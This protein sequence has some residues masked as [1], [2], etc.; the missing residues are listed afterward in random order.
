MVVN[1]QFKNERTWHKF[2]QD[3]PLQVS[4]I[5][6]F[7]L[8][9]HKIINGN[10]ILLQNTMTGEEYSQDKTYIPQNSSIIVRRI[11][12]YS[13][14]NAIDLSIM[15]IKKEDEVTE[16]EKMS[17]IL[18]H[19][20]DYLNKQIKSKVKIEEPKKNNGQTFK[21]P[22]TIPPLHYICHRCKEK[23]HYIQH[24]P[25]NGDPKF[26]IVIYKNP[27]GIPKMFLKEM[28]EEDEG[29][30]KK[31]S[32]FV[33]NNKRSFN[34]FVGNNTNCIEKKIKNF[35]ICPICN[36]KIKDA[37]FI[38]CCFM[39]FCNECIRQQV[40]DNNSNCPLCDNEVSPQDLQINHSLRRIILN[41]E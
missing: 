18:K 33:V 12:K 14:L 25:T 24:C 8:E 28:N 23:G 9:R 37:T 6:K 1:Y 13:L 38:V 2:I 27:T 4:E 41:D 20:E 19:S 31:D 26:D 36:Q 5:K 21:S 10:G 16:D 15:P 7:I 40:C 11:P 3:G 22:G 32:K 17:K 39:S 35:M 34:Q 30:M 29:T